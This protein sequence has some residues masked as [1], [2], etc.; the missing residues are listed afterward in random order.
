MHTKPTLH[1]ALMCNHSNGGFSSALT[2][3]DALAG[4]YDVQAWSL[5]GELYK[6][7]AEMFEARNVSLKIADPVALIGEGEHLF[8]YM[9]DYP[10][11]FSN[12]SD[13]WKVQMQRAA[14]VQ[15]AFNRTLGAIPIETWLAKHLN[16][17]Y[18]QNSHME[19]EWQ[20]LVRSNILSR[21]ATEVLAP[22][23]VLS[24]FL[25]IEEPRSAP[26]V[27][28]R[29]AGDGAV[30]ESAV[31]LY[32][33]LAEDHPKS[34]FWF[35]PAPSVL[36]DACSHNPQ[37]RFFEPNEITVIDFLQACNI[38][39]LTYKDHIPVPG[40]RSLVEAMAAG[41]A[42]VVINREG[43]KERIIHGESGYCADN[44]D[45]FYHY[46]NMLATNAD[47]R[48]KISAGARARARTF[49]VDDW[50]KRIDQSAARIDL[51]QNKPQ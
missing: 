5:F 8:F 48:S 4:Q 33:R 46:A 29:L 40:P 39:L 42:P 35:M 11:L 41:C 23:I 6:G 38:F 32:E 27:F 12:F 45:D 28:G 19:S 44:D 13:D 15:I 34:E 21:V 22:P 20:Q 7:H 25:N 51:H 37:F 1:F 43:P 3:I 49:K 18:F 24:P 30:P 14:S 10:R 47:L 31:R 50:V 16:R 36:H 17:I 2:L 9:N 26:L